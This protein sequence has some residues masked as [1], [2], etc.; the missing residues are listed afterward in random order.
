LPSLPAKPVSGGSDKALPP[1]PSHANAVVTGLNPHRGADKGLRRRNAVVPSL[2]RGRYARDSGKASALPEQPI[3]VSQNRMPEGKS[4]KVASWPSQVGVKLGKPT[5]ATPG[6]VGKMLG[7]LGVPTQ[8][9]RD[10]VDTLLGIQRKCMEQLMTEE[11]LGEVEHW[12]RHPDDFREKLML[13]SDGNGRLRRLTTAFEGANVF[14]RTP[15][16]LTSKQRRAA[17]QLQVFINAPEVKANLVRMGNA[18]T[19][20]VPGQNVEV[21]LTQLNR[22][23]GLFREMV[24]D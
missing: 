4:P 14:M 7:A 13:E 18:A 12:L 16:A 17:K 11:S 6:L 21:V 8:A 9:E 15:N 19:Y 5:S 1:L 20:A 10:K 24:T 3:Q 22:A 23:V 2:A